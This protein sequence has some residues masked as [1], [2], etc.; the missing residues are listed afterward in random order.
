MPTLDQALLRRLALKYGPT[1]NLESDSEVLT[2]ILRQLAAEEPAAE[3]PKPGEPTE[4]LVDLP[5]Y[6]KTY[7][8]GYNKENYSRSDY[9]RYDRTVSGA[10]LNDEGLNIV[11]DADVTIVDRLR[12]PGAG[13]RVN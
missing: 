11:P 10:G 9:H 4:K 6:D 8:E 2:E 13:Q 7:T 5:S 3:E 1:I 12:G